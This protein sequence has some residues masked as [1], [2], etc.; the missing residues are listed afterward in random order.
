MRLK[1]YTVM[2][3]MVVSMLSVL[4][5]VAAINVIE[6]FQQQFAS[7]EEDTSIALQLSNL[8]V[9]LQED[10]FNSNQI[11]RFENSLA[12]SFPDHTVRY[13]IDSDFIVREIN[14]SWSK[15]D[16]SF[17]TVENMLTHFN[18]KEVLKGSVSAL[19]ISILHHDRP[20]LISVQKELDAKNLIKETN[21]Y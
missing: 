5:V 18:Q 11:E 19:Q 4:T 6:M 20:F 8:Q 3:L 13:Q 15:R 9:L 17:L 16:T 14:T 21:G 12:F 1:A 7:Y 10:F 2:E